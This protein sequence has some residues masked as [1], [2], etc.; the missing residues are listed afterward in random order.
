MLR[1]LIRSWV[2]LMDLRLNYKFLLML[3]QNSTK[4]DQSIPDERLS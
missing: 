2:V 4:L 1:F 3:Y